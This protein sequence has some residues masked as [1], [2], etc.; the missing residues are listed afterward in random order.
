MEIIAVAI[1]FAAL[2]VVFSNVLPRLKALEKELSELRGQAG[3]PSG[4]P[5]NDEGES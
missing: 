5:P 3:S 2:G 4:D 1:G